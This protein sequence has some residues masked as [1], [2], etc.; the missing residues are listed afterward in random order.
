MGSQA[1]AVPMRYGELVWDERDVLSDHVWGVLS[2]EVNLQMSK[3]DPNP[4]PALSPGE[5]NR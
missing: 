4:N 5:P 1:I 3:H 2:G